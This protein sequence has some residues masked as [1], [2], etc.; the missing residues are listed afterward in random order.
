MRIMLSLSDFSL[1]VLI[2]VLCTAIIRLILSRL[3]KNK[4]IIW[5]CNYRHNN[6]IAVMEC[7]VRLID[8]WMLKKLFPL[9]LLCLMVSEIVYRFMSGS[10]DSYT[11]LQTELATQKNIEI[12]FVQELDKVDQEQD[13]AE[14]LHRLHI[15]ENF[16]GAEITSTMYE[17]F[18]TR[19]SS[20][21]VNG[22]V[23]EYKAL[24]LSES[25]SAKYNSVE[26]VYIREAAQYRESYLKAPG[27]ANQYHYGRA[28]NDAGMTLDDLSFSLK[29]DIMSES[30]FALED[31]L[32]YADRN[33]GDKNRSVI[34]NTNYV[35]LLNG[36]LFLHNAPL[37]AG[38]YDGEG[39]I[40]CFYVEAYVCFEL[41]LA[42]TDL[43]DENY[44][45]LAY[46]VG[47]AGEH[48]IKRIDK[49]REPDLYKLIGDKVLARYEAAL[50]CIEN[51]PELYNQEDYMGKNIRDGIATLHALGFS[52]DD[53]KTY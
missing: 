42:G 44:A 31:F 12:L 8:Y 53:R 39:Y 28:L 18:Q 40:N 4:Y 46:Y 26:S 24:D 13:E 2:I 48:I 3:A 34:I 21:Y 11:Y 1:K 14:Q 38:S 5:K 52:S 17:F 27:I 45:L 43:Q 35:A 15:P 16:V 10:A 36:K 7:I 32:S 51:A 37:A 9:A 29:F 19:L 20:I 49:D 47:N 6:L 23:E 50:E 30:V 22:K 41:G 25:K 33:V